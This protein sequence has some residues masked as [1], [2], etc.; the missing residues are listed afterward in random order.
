[1]AGED[2]PDTAPYEGLLKAV[3]DKIQVEPFLFIIAIAALIVALVVLG[4]GLGDANFR[5]V[6]VV[7][8]VL[9]AAAIAVYYLLEVRKST[10]AA[11]QAPVTP[12]AAERP[13][14]AMEAEAGGEIGDAAQETEGAADQ[15]MRAAGPGSRLQNVRQ[16]SGGRARPA[17]AAG[18]RRGI[19]PDLNRRLKEALLDCAPLETNEALHRML[20][21]DRLSAWRNRLPA[22]DSAQARAETIVDFFHNKENVFGENVLALFLQVAAE[23]LEPADACR[24]RLLA[25]AEEL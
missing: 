23:R 10:P 20:V 7:I 19:D 22:T 12:P 1:M 17:G 25:L 21:D 18:R 16:S 5:F 2:K 14:Q 4:A 3:V 9:A 11:D 24:E 13:T 8:A 6:V 15:R